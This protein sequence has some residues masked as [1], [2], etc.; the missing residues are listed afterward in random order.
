MADQDIGRFLREVR[1]A[2]GLT[3]REAA[4]QS[5]VS[6]PYLSQV[7]TG[8]RRPGPSIL[9]R[10]APVYGVSVHELMVR[11]GHLREEPSLPIDER[12]EVERAYQFV[13]TDPRFRTGTKPK[14]DRPLEVKRFVVEMY[15]RLTGKRILG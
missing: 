11:A 10:L 13:L 1:Q 9:R 7:E 12:Q 15:E 2:V 4:R 14:G 5:G 8:Q 6:N 3:L